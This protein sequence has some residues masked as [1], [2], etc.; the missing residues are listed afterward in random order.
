MLVKKY[1]NS[2]YSNGIAI[3]N[4]KDDVKYYKFID[5]K[6]KEYD[7]SNKDSELNNF[8]IL[9]II[10][11]K[12]MIHQIYQ[13]IIYALIDTIT[14]DTAIFNKYYNLQKTLQ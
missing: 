10:K 7:Y 3:L 8:F 12:I 4:D 14:K 5:G 6:Y 2:Y 9:R 13:Q 11:K 1:I